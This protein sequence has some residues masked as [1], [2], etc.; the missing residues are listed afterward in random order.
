MIGR[1][2]PCNEGIK[3]TAE[4]TGTTENSFQIRRRGDPSDALMMQKS[5]ARSTV[6]MG[7]I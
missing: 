4:V 5:D 7:M 6:P 2:T 1:S 3:E